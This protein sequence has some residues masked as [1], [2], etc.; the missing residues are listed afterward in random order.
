MSGHDAP[1]SG[2]A[3][4]FIRF[5]WL[6]VVLLTGV[7][8]FLL[9]FVWMIAT[10]LKTDDEL[11]APNWFPSLPAFT[12]QSPYVLPAPELEKPLPVELPDWQRVLPELH[13]A[14]AGTVEAFL[15]AHP[16]PKVDRAASVQSAT[17]LLINRLSARLESRLWSGPMPALLESYSSMLSDEAIAA[18]LDDR[19]AR[20]EI[21]GLMLRTI[22]GH[23][24]QL[25]DERSAADAWKVVSGPAKLR[26][27]RK[28]TTYLQ[29]EFSSG[30][31]EPIVLECPIRAS[32]SLGAWHKVSFSFR[33]DSSWHR[34]DAEIRRAGETWVSDRPTYAGLSRTASAIFQF[35]SFEDE[36]L[37][38]RTWIPMIK[39]SNAPASGLPSMLRLTFRP[40][41]TAQAIYGKVQ[42][43]Y[44]RAFRSVPFWR[45]VGNSLILV[46]LTTVGTLFSSTFVAYAFAR[47]HWPGRGVALVLLLS[48]LMLPSQVTMIPSFM[49]WRQLG[50][51]NT[52]NPLWVPAFFGSAF[53]IFLMIQHM[54]TIP[55]ELEEAARIDGLNA[56]QTW[57][58]V[59]V[60]LVK[61]AAAAIAI[62]TVMA[63]W[64][65]FMG[66]LIYLRDQAKF[67]LSLGL[68]ATRIDAGADWTM[69]MAGNVLMTLPM[70]VMFVVF[71]RYFIQG[72]LVGGVKG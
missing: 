7:A 64:N 63:A 37:K 17:A 24:E 29:Y 72:M 6:H 49:I 67:P 2:L 55:K 46:I 68:F 40:S 60:P 1:A 18:S 25:C 3:R 48:T 71:Q 33:A 15:D 59:M 50:W 4:Y 31:D 38:P 8:L 54:K 57:W 70:I 9:P 51:Y 44:T 14:T 28:G 34:F 30:S 19:T 5:G 23:I 16:D 58:Y 36:M 32:A 10:S 56:L 39:R 41:S 62:M 26:T 20:F 27:T 52:L 13:R 43:N 35:P 22:D 61:P 47:L 12:A 69:I 11:T 45:Y 42:A 65:E 53:F 21:I 66:P